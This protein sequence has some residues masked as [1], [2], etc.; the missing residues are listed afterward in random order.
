M[1][2]FTLHE[3]EAREWLTELLIAHEM[4]IGFGEKNPVG[5]V[6]SP[7][8]GMAWRPTDPGEEDGVF[9]L[10]RAAQTAHVLTAPDEMILDYEFIDD[11]DECLFRWLL[12]ITLPAPLKLA[13]LAEP[14]PTLEEPD[15]SGVEAA[16]A[17]LRAAAQTANLLLQQLSD[18]IEASK[19]PGHGS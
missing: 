5:D 11:G 4:G 2:R 1:A 14:L 8:I 16:M 10:V 17:I 19:T 13:T 9:L 12:D 7:P 15:A 3:E 6:G 18:Y